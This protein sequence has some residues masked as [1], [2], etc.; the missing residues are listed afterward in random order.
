MLQNGMVVVV[1]MGVFLMKFRWVV[2]DSR[3]SETPSGCTFEVV[4]VISMVVVPFGNRTM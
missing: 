2:A 1:P 4:W 3:I